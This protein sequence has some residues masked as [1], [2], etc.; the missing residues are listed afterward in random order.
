MRMKSSLYI[1]EL[2]IYQCTIE[3]TLCGRA[4]FLQGLRTQLGLT[5]SSLS[6]SERSREEDQRESKVKKLLALKATLGA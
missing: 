2:E 4:P 6:S 3:A 5:L 1:C